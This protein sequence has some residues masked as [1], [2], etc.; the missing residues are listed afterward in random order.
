MATKIPHKGNTCQVLLIISTS[1][2]TPCANPFHASQI[3]WQATVLKPE[4]YCLCFHRA[5]T[6]C[7][8][9]HSAFF[10][11]ANEQHS[12][13]ECFY[14]IKQ[15][16]SSWR[17]TIRSRNCKLIF[18]LL[19]QNIQYSVSSMGPKPDEA[20]NMSKSQRANLKALTSVLPN[21]HRVSSNHTCRAPKATHSLQLC[22][23]CQPKD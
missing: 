7:Y 6:N 12:R 23:T 10:Y 5:V 19:L 2:I 14:T 4:Y 16:I 9:F 13:S 21:P 22:T 8:T 3:C 1:G 11:P 15:N 20:P 18:L 17:S